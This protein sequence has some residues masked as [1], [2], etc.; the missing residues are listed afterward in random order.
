MVGG[1]GGLAR[2]LDAQFKAIGTT[3]YVRDWRVATVQTFDYQNYFGKLLAKHQPDMVI[4]NL[5]AN[6]AF[7][8][9]P[10]SLAG[11]VASIARKASQG[12]RPCYWIT[13]PLWKPPDTGIVQVIK[14]NAKLAGA[15]GEA[16]GCVVFDSSALALPKWPDGIHPNNEGGA[17]WADRFWDFY[18]TARVDR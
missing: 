10:K 11:F 12:G 9:N 17:I 2:A 5:G 18:V 15:N 4:I 3:T 14:D 16:K 13:P 1:A 7:V 6:D 8:P